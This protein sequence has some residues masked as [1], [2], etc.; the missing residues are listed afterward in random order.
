[1]ATYTGANVLW[2][3]E[4]LKAV[5]HFDSQTDYIVYSDT[6]YDNSGNMINKVEFKLSEGNNKVNPLGIASSNSM[7]IEVFDKDN[8][9][10]PANQNSYLYGKVVNG[11]Q[12]DM[13]ISYDGSAWS[14]YGKWLITNVSCSYSEGY[15]GFTNIQ[16]SDKM[17]HI[18]GLDIPEIQA[19]Q[20]MYAADLIGAVMEGIGLSSSEYYVDDRINEQLTYGITTGNKVRDFINNI[21]QVLTARAV[22]NRSGVIMFVPALDPYEDANTFE[23]DESYA[24]TFVNQNTNNINYN[25]LRVKYLIDGGAGER[26][27]IFNV[28]RALSV[29]NNN[30][31]DIQ[32]SRKA[33]SIEQIKCLFRK[34]VSTADITNVV[35]SG[36]QNGIQLTVSVSGE[37]ISDCNIVGIGIPISTQD[38]YYDLSIGNTAVVGGMTFEFDTKMIMDSSKAQSIATKLRQYL[39]A[40][41][42]TIGMNGSPLSPRMDVGDILVLDNTGTM[43]DGTYKITA[44][45]ISFSESY[46]VSMTLIRVEEEAQ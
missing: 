15:H 28:N 37:A 18:G 34:G 45:N 16:A 38:A 11:V 9:L 36:F 4:P 46:S 35:Y 41:G 40:I 3:G 24:G 17:D 1:M 14:P 30:I 22:L 2:K 43:Y 29:G 20:G 5:F 7:S 23:V 25:K 26:D 21:C 27:E 19:Y 32:F 39:V 42:R 8:A 10:S 12:I 31:T 44:L 6:Q 13:Y 33:L